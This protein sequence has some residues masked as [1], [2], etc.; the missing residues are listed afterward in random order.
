V[1]GRC[2]ITFTSFL[3]AL[4]AASALL[5][6]DKVLCFLDLHTL[7]TFLP[8]YFHSSL[9]HTAPEHPLN[10]GHTNTLSLVGIAYNSR[11]LC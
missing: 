8:F 10:L 5:L 11:A 9:I 6:R 3:I 7:T 4:A 1:R 2:S